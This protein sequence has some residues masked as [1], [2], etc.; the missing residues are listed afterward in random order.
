MID[1][2]TPEKTE[3]RVFRNTGIAPHSLDAD[4]VKVLS[5]LQRKG[6]ETYLVGG[7]VRDL[8]L[9]RTPKDFDIA[10]EARP[11]QVKALFRNCR[12]IGRRFKLAHVHFDG[13][14][15]EV[16]TFRTMPARRR[17]EEELLIRSDNEF[18]TAEDDAYRRDFTINGLFYDPTEDRILDWVGGI[19]DLQLRLVRA[20]GS[21]GIRMREDP[22]RILRAI[23]FASRLGFSIE[24]GTWE[25]MCRVSRD[26]AKGAPPRI[27]EE[28]LRLLK[29]GKALRAFQ[30]L[31]DCRALGVVLEDLHGFLEHTE[32]EARLRFWKKLEA[33][34]ALCQEGPPP[35]TALCLA[36]LFYDFL[37]ARRNGPVGDRDLGRWVYDQLDP[38]FRAL[39]LP[40]AEA[41]KMRRIYVVQNRFSVP[42]GKG[43]R[44]GRPSV[45]VKQESFPEAFR[46][47]RLRCM[48]TGRGFEDLE[49]WTALERKE[50]PPEDGSAPEDRLPEGA[51]A[52]A[53]PEEPPRLEKRKRRARGSKKSGGRKEAGTSDESP[54]SPEESPAKEE[55][56]GKRRKRRRKRSEKAKPLPEIAPLPDIELDPSQIPTYGSVI[57]DQADPGKW[58]APGRGKGKKRKVPVEETPYVPPPPPEEDPRGNGEDEPD[59]FGDW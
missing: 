47:F 41:A 53:S 27:L 12:V 29:S 26:L 22:I 37:E 51:T 7:C 32:T 35:S 43:G 9:G 48:A 11:R 17:N 2:T 31:R 6:F 16:S 58:K 59:I 54:S 44:T 23:K 57:G 13:K 36:A 4:A 28:I 3:L 20:I 1:T 49:R 10:T 46:F 15:L 25:A 19:H 8:L 50:R 38:L 40:R 5:R 42:E 56:G 52:P 39:S 34:D 24:K 18:G 30:L 14:I 55:K 45:F 21:P 33:L